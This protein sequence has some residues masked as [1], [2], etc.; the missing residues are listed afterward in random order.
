M[1]IAF[2][3]NMGWPDLIIILIVALLIFG[4][5]LPSV[6]RSVGRSAG[7][8]RRGFREAEE[9]LEGETGDRGSGGTKAG[10]DSKSGGGPAGESGGPPGPKPCSPGT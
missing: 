5:R 3:S 1:P 4:H 6:M 10:N 7:E 9:E 2:L 8:L